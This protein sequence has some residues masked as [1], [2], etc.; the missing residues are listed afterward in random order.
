MSTQAGT[1][2]LICEAGLPFKLPDGYKPSDFLYGED[3]PWPSQPTDGSACKIAPEV[4]SN[5]K[6]EHYPNRI[7]EPE[8]KEW[9]AS[10]GVYYD[11]KN[12]VNIAWDAIN[13]SEDVL[14]IDWWTWRK[15]IENSLIETF[16][17]IWAEF[18]RIPDS[19]ELGFDIGALLD[20]EGQ[21]PA[22]SDAT[23]TDLIAHGL[24]SKLLSELDQSDKTFFEKLLNDDT[25]E[26]WKSDQTHM[27]VV[28]NPWADEYVAPAIVLLSR[29]KNPASGQEY[30][31]QVHGIVL[32]SQSK[33]GGPYDRWELFQPRDGK[34]WQLAK[35]FALQGALVRINLID[36][37]KVHFPFDAINAITKSVL[38]RTNPVLELLRPHLFLSLPVDN[39]V[40]EGKRSL[41]NRIKNYPYAPYPA[42]GEEIRKVFPFYWVGS[43]T[44]IDP[45]EPWSQGRD[46]AFPP[47][48]FRTE[49][50]AIP[51]KYGTFL[52]RYYIPILSFTRGVIASI[53]AD[54]KEW[55]VIGWWA[56]RCASWIPGFPNGN[57]I[58][59]R[60]TLAKTCASII[61]SC[62]I[63]HSADHWLMHEMFRKKLPT[64]YI[65]RDKPPPKPT[66]GVEPDF[67]PTVRLVTDSIPA[68]LA[69]LLFF[70]P[71]NTTLLIESTYDFKPELQP[72]VDTFHQQLKVTEAALRKEFP[73][74]GIKL[75]PS[76]HKEFEEDCFAA[77]IQ[78]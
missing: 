39:A 28:R 65:M 25:R 24:L 29:P 52:Y 67:R 72:L 16:I 46:N 48:R 35:Y 27:R 77:G 76:D 3:G 2:G 40:L 47:F 8:M 66:P 75:A 61:W 19:Q 45:A 7:P 59:D 12:F 50:Q 55:G 36:H 9:Q 41:L 6:N 37:T 17:G 26:F 4:L 22:L 58:K 64:P 11:D 78:F 63:V 60:E 32:W 14:G 70:R 18:G 69:D 13:N 44:A 49:P 43:G 31:F 5:K 62:A 68:S 56:D 38:P 74:F 1:S 20:T 30:D 51:S 10:L 33:R 23:F 34:S 15:D 57:E 53:P 73:E 54:S 42:K 21:Y 71:H